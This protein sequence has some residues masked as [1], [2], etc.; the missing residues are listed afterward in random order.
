L[1]PF[2]GSGTTAWVARHHGRRAVGVELN[3][4]YAQLAADRLKQGVLDLGGLV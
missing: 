1:D 4:S 2:L 3:E